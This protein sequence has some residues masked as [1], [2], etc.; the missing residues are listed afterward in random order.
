MAVIFVAGLE[1]EP[2]KLVKFTSD[3]VIGAYKKLGMFGKKDFETVPVQVIDVQALWAIL[4]AAQ[5]FGMRHF[6]LAKSENMDNET[7]LVVGP[8]EPDTLNKL[9]AN[10][11]LFS[12]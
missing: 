10:F 7:I 1:K 2:A 9:S 8:E 3:A 12:E 6:L 11:R 4:Q 5:K